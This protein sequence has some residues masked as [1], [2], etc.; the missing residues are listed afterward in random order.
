MQRQSSPLLLLLKLLLLHSENGK[1]STRTAASRLSPQYEQAS[2]GII[3]N[4]P[5]YRIAHPPLDEALPLRMM[6]MIMIII[7]I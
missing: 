1:K 6:R 5:S 3:I 4:S 7:L 2:T